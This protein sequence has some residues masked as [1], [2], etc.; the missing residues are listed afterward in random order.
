MKSLGGAKTSHMHRHAKSTIEKTP[1]NN[2]IH[3]GTNDISNKD[4]DPEKNSGRYYKPIKRKKEGGSNVII[5]GLVPRK[6]YLNIKLRNV[7]NRLRDYCRNRM[8]TFLKHDNINAKTH[9]NKISDLHLN[10]KGVSLFNENF[11][12]LLNTLDSEN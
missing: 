4:A 3:S 9:C 5:S 12:N 11:V 10:S 8:L 7:D 2:I 6:R 1:E